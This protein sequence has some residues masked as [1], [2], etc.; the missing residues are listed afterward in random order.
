MSSRKLNSKEGWEMDFQT[1]DKNREI[2][3]NQEELIGC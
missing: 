3:S 1:R 2:K